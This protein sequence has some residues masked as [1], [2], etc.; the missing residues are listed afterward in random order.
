MSTEWVTW[1]WATDKTGCPRASLYRFMQEGRIRHR[2]GRV[3]RGS[4]DRA[5]VEA[6]AT[7]FAAEKRSL[8]IEKA[9]ARAAASRQA[10]HGPPPDGEVWLDSTTAALV[11]GVSAQYVARLATNGRYPAVYRGRQWWL[12]RSHVEQLAAARIFTSQ[13]RVAHHP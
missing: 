8:A 4:L 5:S 11:I 1:Q 9:R 10:E 2:R 6:F 12:R 3:R 7:W 13:A